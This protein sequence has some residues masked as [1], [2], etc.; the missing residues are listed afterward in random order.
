M[1]FNKTNSKSPEKRVV[2]TD[3]QGV[4][5][6]AVLVM[7]HF[8]W[9]FAREKN[10]SKKRLQIWEHGLDRHSHRTTEQEKHLWVLDIVLAM[11]HI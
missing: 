5:T 1:K 10:G 8:L 2:Q 7:R 9:L 11:E 4:G 3:W 6:G